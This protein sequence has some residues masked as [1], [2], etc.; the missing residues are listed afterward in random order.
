MLRRRRACRWPG[1][2]IGAWLIATLVAP[3]PPVRAQPRADGEPPSCTALA[4]LAVPVDAAARQRHLGRLD[5][6]RERC[7]GDAGYLAALGGAWLELGDA[8][9]ALLWLERALLLDPGL[10]AARADH[11]LALAALGQPQALRDLTREWGQRTDVPPA[12][13]ERLARQVEAAQADPAR[14]ELRRELMLLAGAETNLNQ[15]PTLSELTLTPPEGPIDLPLLEPLEPRAGGA[16]LVEAALQLEYRVL[17]GRSWLVGATAT[18]RHAPAASFTDWYVAQAAASWIESWDAWRLQVSLSELWS[19][20]RLEDDYRADRVALGADRP[21]GGCLHRGVFDA[22]RRHHSAPILDGRL[23]G[24]LYSAR[25]RLDAEA[26][27]LV[28]VAGRW[29]VDEAIDPDRP[30][31]TQDRWSM[32]L[33][34]QGHLPQRRRLDMGARYTLY[35]DREGYSPLLENNARRWQ[36]LASLSVEFAQPLDALGPSWQR[37][38]WIVLTQIARQRSNLELFRYRT[39]T[40]YSGLRV[41]W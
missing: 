30:G 39:G 9:Q 6:A 22:E 14:W 36:R 28:T 31:G 5:A 8:A 27:W 17:P 10:L 19:S 11:A 40:L 34:L 26:R 2:W 20:G 32:G 15:S 37:A 29:A 13:V 7:I 16:L 3:T 35:D 4:L 1:G 24:L 25:C 23:A 33:R 18:A 41:A 21:W 38:E 12:L